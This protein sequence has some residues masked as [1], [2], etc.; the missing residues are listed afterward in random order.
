[1]KLTTAIRRY[2]AQLR[3]DGKSPLTRTVY[4]RDLRTFKQWIGKPVDI[5][6][7]TSRVVSGYLTSETF[8]HTQGGKPK[9]VSSLNRAK[10]ALR[11]FFQFLADADYMKHNPTTFVRLARTTRKPPAVLADHEIGALF[12]TL[13]SD[14]SPIAKRDQL[15]FSLFLGTGIRLGSLVALNVEDVD[16]AQEILRTN[17][18]NGAQQI[19]FLS[20]RLKRRLKAHLQSHTAKPDGPLFLSSRG[21]RIG[22]RQVQLRLGHWLD[23]AGITGGYT[24]H[25]L[26]HSF[27]TRVYEKTGD[28]RLT[29]RALGHKRI[30]TTEIYT[31][32]SD[33]RL[34]AAV[35]SLD[36]LDQQKNSK[37]RRK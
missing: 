12:K 4:L 17:G 34:K 26:R 37:K 5:G 11:S 1:M 33:T 27:A 24:V 8:T 30:T 7:I 25:T 2:D 23:K 10:S 18:K 36:V 6:K 35:Q 32:V 9:S 20:T 19:V 31:H 28:L 22:A 29:Q 13:E 14:R 21:K 15:I 16:V 3:A